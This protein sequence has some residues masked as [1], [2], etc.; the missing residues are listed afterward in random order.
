MAKLSFSKLGLTKNNIA[1]KIVTYN[2]QNIEVKQYLPVND[3]VNL[4][5]TI[6][7][8]SLLNEENRFPNPIQIE[9][10]TVIE[11]I[12]KYTN[13]NFTD[14]QKE[15]YAKLYDLC[16][17]SG[18]WN[19]ISENL[20]KEDYDLTLKFIDTTIKAYYG[21]QNSVFGIIESMNKEYQQMN[22]DASEIQEKL[23]DPENLT[24]LKDVL[25][26]LG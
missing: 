14:K 6:L 2:E 23:S 26:K 9:V 24:L 19:V 12:N 18:L 4:V 21:Y 20:N 7:N 3:K 15:D 8:Y 1:T 5:A 13:I 11:T 25:N 22:F 10:L 17:S 16:V